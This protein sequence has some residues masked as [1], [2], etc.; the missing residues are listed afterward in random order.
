ML[1]VI[2]HCVHIAMVSI[3]VYSDQYKQSNEDAVEQIQKGRGFIKTFVQ[4]G[5][6]IFYYISGMA[7]YNYDCEKKG[8]V[9][10]V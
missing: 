10:Y 6:P 7:A 1:V 2:V 8:F 9:T 5:I 4:F 3:D